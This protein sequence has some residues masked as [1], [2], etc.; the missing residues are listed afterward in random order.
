MGVGG[1]AGYGDE[2][3]GPRLSG[4]S[5]TSSLQQLRSWRG[6]HLPDAR[7]LLRKVGRFLKQLDSDSRGRYLPPAP[8]PLPTLRSPGEASA[9]PSGRVG[10]E[11]PKRRSLGVRGWRGLGVPQ[12]PEAEPSFLPTPPK[13]SPKAELEH[14]RQGT[15]PAPGLPGPHSPRVPGVPPPSRRGCHYPRSGPP[16]HSR[17]L[18]CSAGPAGAGRAQG[19]ARAAMASSRALP[20][21]Q[22]PVLLP[23]QAA[24]GGGGSG[25]SPRARGG[26]GVGREVR[27]QGRAS[28]RGERS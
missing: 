9:P 25:S 17:A 27:R 3:R 8:C 28:W 24:G 12:S 20:A 21:S 13:P 23:G 15:S 18:P 2:E 4:A 1:R 26:A 11:S 6:L 19:A 10:A 7:R 5:P 22:G 16:G 14:S